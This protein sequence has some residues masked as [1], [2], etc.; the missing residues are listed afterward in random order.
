MSQHDQPHILTCNNSKDYSRI[1]W[2]LAKKGTVWWSRP[3]IILTGLWI[4]IHSEVLD[5]INFPSM[6]SLVVGCEERCYTSA[7]GQWVHYQCMTF[8]VKFNCRLIVKCT[9]LSTHHWGGVAHAA[10]SK[11]DLRKKHSRESEI[12]K[13]HKYYSNTITTGYRFI[14]VVKHLTHKTNSL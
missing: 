12:I 10:S 14:Y 2:I 9:R 4:S 7:F 13:C 11:W 5:S 8:D 6:N 1:L 3:G